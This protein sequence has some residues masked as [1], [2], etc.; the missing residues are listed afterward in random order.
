VSTPRIIEEFKNETTNELLKALL[1][2]H[3]TTPETS[4]DEKML[5][6]VS[7]LDEIFRGRQNET[8]KY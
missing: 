1:E 3:T 4:Q 6:L 2:V 8:D 5:I 7:K